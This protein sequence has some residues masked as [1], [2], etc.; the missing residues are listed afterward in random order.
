MPTGLPWDHPDSD[1]LGDIRIAYSSWPLEER[2]PA[3]PSESSWRLMGYTTAG[4]ETAN[5]PPLIWPP[6]D[7]PVRIEDYDERP[8]NLAGLFDPGQEYEIART[9]PYCGRHRGGEVREADVFF[10]GL[11]AFMIFC[12][13]LLIVRYA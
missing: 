7:K 4:H 11:G 2:L 10:F 8:L 3:Y 13:I 5:Q 6:S 1:P 12:A 9:G